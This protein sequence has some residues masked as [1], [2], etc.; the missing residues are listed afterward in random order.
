MPKWEFGGCPNF[1]VYYCGW[2]PNPLS[3]FD[4]L[5]G[6]TARIPPP[7]SESVLHFTPLNLCPDGSC[8]QSP[9]FSSADA[10]K[11]LI[12]VPGELN[13]YFHVAKGGK[14]ELFCLVDSTRATNNWSSLMSLLAAIKLQCAHAPSISNDSCQSNSSPGAETRLHRF[15]HTLLMACLSP[16]SPCQQTCLQ[17]APHY[18]PDDLGQASALC[19]IASFLSY[20]DSKPSE[21]TLQQRIYIPHSFLLFLDKTKL[22]QA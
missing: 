13:N 12:Q 3:H 15:S 4:R 7:L 10:T 22:E 17:G 2:R 18:P 6:Y 21:T 19:S 1:A 8:N 14:S 20:W 11:L 16:Q 5:D 9:T